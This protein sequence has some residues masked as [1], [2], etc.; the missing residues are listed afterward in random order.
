MSENPC[1]QV[2]ING[3]EY[4]L[5]DQYEPAKKCDGMLYVIVRTFSAGVFAGYLDSHNGQECVLRNARRIW[6][7][8]G[9]ASLSELAMRGTAKPENCKFP[10]PVDRITLTQSIE[11]IDCTE[12]AR[13]SIQGVSEWTNQ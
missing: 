10:C 2:S 11:L 7:W 5:K 13:K 3:H 12:V 1:K 4:V 6:Y 9:A 8:S